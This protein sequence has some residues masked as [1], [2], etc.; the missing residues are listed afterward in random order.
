MKAIRVVG[1]G[2]V[3]VAEVEPP[4]PGV[5]E[6]L[7]KVHAC[8]VCGSDLNAW[9]GGSG[10]DYPL[11]SG[12]P[13]HE[14]LGQVA[15]VGAADGAAGRAVGVCVMGRTWKGCARYTLARANRLVALEACDEPR[16]GEPLACAVN[17]LRR[18]APRAGERLAVVGFGYLA[19]LVVQLLPAW[20][21]G[22]W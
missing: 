22:E 4:I 19:A 14:V 12:A 15:A 21:V 8:G 11:P 10:V 9:R 7:I 20:G 2:R 18:A 17:V 16:L 1:P 5:G 13:G 3:D 6:V